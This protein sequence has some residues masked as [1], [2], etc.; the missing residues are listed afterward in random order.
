VP[1]NY[2]AD[3]RSLMKVATYVRSILTGGTETVTK[4]ICSLTSEINRVAGLSLLSEA[5]ERKKTLSASLTHL[6]TTKQRL[7]QV[8]KDAGLGGLMAP[9][10]TWNKSRDV[11]QAEANHTEVI[12]KF[13]SPEECQRRTARISQHNQYVV[14]ERERLAGLKKDLETQKTTSAVL[15][16]FQKDAAEAI[17]AAH[18]DGWI[19]PTF[20][21]GFRAM[22]H[23]LESGRIAEATKFLPLLEFQR[24]PSS[25]QYDNWLKESSSIFE[26]AY[27]GY[28]GF[29]ASGAYAE[30]TTRSMALAEPALRPKPLELL[31]RQL[32]PAD[33]WQM[34]AA[35]LTD[36]RSLKTDVLWA[37]YWSMFQSSQWI[38][39]ALAEAD[40]REDVFTGKV[41]AQI[42]RWI[43]D[44]G[45]KRIQQFGY[46]IARSYIGTFD[47][48]GTTEETRLGADLGMIV[49]INIGGLVCR[50]V[51]LFQAKKVTNGLAEIGSTSSQ[52]P[53]LSARPRTGFYLF[54]HQANHPLRSP[55][56]TVCSAN[57]L[58]QCISAAGRHIDAEYLPINVRTLG[59]DWANFLTFGLCNAEAELGESF[60]S[61]DE[62]MAILGN[63][64]A[65]HLPKHLFVVAITDEPRV[66]E[67][68]AEIRE[69]YVESVKLRENKHTNERGLSL[70]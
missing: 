8:K 1:A 9:V 48:A 65:R 20:S 4:N 31:K 35:I 68:R 63:G 2:I 45:A 40:A 32:H 52:L 21:E 60:S 50:K 14:T 7:Q 6:N 13:E 29:A 34:L 23:H 19:A 16:A 51:A 46:P 44:W 17:A 12:Q 49:D 5:E 28:T 25:Q 47:I 41:I 3:R 58:A 11:R 43:S 38:A 39:R 30:T 70:S 33:Q 26:Q 67:L 56:P 64:D 55:A 24:Q 42:D 69:H 18:S 22:A 66:I 27:Q 15:A 53:L 59:W 54:Y 10:Q 36:P 57:T 61:A 62:A 37:I